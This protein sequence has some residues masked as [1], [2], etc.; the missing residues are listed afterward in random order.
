MTRGP[1]AHVGT[2]YV[3]NVQDLIRE[4]PSWWL[5]PLSFVTDMETAEKLTDD[6]SRQHYETGHESFRGVTQLLSLIHNSRRRKPLQ[7][8]CI[9]AFDKMYCIKQANLK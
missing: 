3:H 2:V 7:S 4:E 9:K 1:R 8:S 6:P 5:N